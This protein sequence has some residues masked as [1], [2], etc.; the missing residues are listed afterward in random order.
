MKTIQLVICGIL[1]ISSVGCRK[2]GCTD[3]EAYNYNEDAKKNDGT[4]K[5]VLGCTDPLSESY[6]P[7]A[8]KDDGSCSY[9]GSVI[10]WY[11]DT[12]SDIYVVD[13][14]TNVRAEST[15]A[16]SQEP[17]DCEDSRGAILNLPTGTHEIAVYYWLGEYY[18]GYAMNVTITPNGCNKIFV[19]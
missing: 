1:A 3:P 13:M 17:T 8:S 14:A 4:C 11:S 15:T 12:A 5:Y 19:N 18:R 7:Q 10:F 9:R 16:L 2:E 6:N